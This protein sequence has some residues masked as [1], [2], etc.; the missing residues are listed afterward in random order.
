MQEPTKNE[1]DGIQH[2][3]TMN[4]SPG[5]YPNFFFFLN[6]PP[7][8]D[9]YPLPLPAPLPIPPSTPCPP[10]EFCLAQCPPPTAMC[11]DT[12]TRR[13]TDQ[14]CSSTQLCSLPNEFCTPRCP[15][16]P[17][18]NSRSEEHTSNSSHLVISY[19]VFCLKK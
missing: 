12:T 6:D 17:P 14:A 13:C 4:P 7:T 18:P 10:N 16:R 2:D 1:A 5:P 8:T 19:A 11:F 9:I 15:P 3:H